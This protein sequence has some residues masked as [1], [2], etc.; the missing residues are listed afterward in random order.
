LGSAR[1]AG[2]IEQDLRVVR[3]GA[4]PRESV[5]DTIESDG[6]GEECGNIQLAGGEMGEGP[7]KFLRV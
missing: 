4:Q 2:R 3:T 5:G 6:A 7:R 1:S